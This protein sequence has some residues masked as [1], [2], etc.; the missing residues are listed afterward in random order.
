MININLK[1]VLYDL[2]KVSNTLFKY[3]TDNLLKAKPEKSHLITNSTQ[4]TQVNIGG[5]AISSSNCEKLLAIHID[6][7]LIFEPHTRSPCKK[8]SQKL[9]AFAR[10]AYYLKFEE[11]KLLFIAF[12]TFQFSHG[13]V[14]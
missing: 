6:N 13:P 9:N 12:I 10:I 4:E 3:F 8:A 2:E 1:K 7:K 11:R 5:M 14:V